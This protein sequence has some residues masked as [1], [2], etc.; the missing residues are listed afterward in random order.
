[1]EGIKLND[2]GERDHEND[3]MDEDIE[4]PEPNVLEISEK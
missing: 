2:D 4:H 3:V 1:M